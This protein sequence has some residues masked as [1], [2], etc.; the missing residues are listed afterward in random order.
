[1]VFKPVRFQIA[2]NVNSQADLWYL[3][4]KKMLYRQFYHPFSNGLIETNRESQ[5]LFSIDQPV[6]PSGI[7]SLFPSLLRLRDSDFEHVL[8]ALLEI[9]RVFYHTLPNFT[10]LWFCSLHPT[11]PFSLFLIRSML[12]QELEVPDP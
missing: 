9:L 12:L 7:V 10:M 5:C 11:Q 1:M 4:P 3:R 6:S 2:M 8:N